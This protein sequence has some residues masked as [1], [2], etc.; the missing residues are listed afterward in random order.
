MNASVYGE[1]QILVS[2]A[3]AVIICT[4]NR[5]RDLEITLSSLVNQSRLPGFLIVVDDSTGRETEDLL[6]TCPVTGRIG[7]RYIHT[8]HPH[9]GLP[10]ARNTGINNVPDGTEIILFLDDDVTLEKDY[11]RIICQVFNENPD[12]EGVTGLITNGYHDRSTVT[13][14]ILAFAG[15][16]NPAL[17]PATLFTQKVTCTGEAMSP[18]FVKP[19]KSRIPA[20]WLSGCNMAYRSAVFSNGRK[21]DERM[22]RYALGED[23]LFS[24][25]LYLQGKILALAPAARLLHRVT[26]VGRLPSRSALMMKFAYRRYVVSRFSAGNPFERAFYVL[27]V[28]EWITASLILSIR[29]RKNLSYFREAVRAFRKVSPVISDIGKGSLEKFN[30][31]L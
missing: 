27:F 12:I 16:V 18:L 11:I 2:S 25:S 14:L 21:F 5:P 22:I 4:K 3:C 10:A 31:I 19:G 28:A 9:I 24:H 26:P 6:K 7:I 29:Y 23:L 15:L 17:V 8:E 20:Q 30:S 13:K 1:S